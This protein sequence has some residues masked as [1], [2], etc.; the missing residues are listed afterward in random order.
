[1]AQIWLLMTYDLSQTCIA[2]DLD[3][4]LVD[5]AED[6]IGALNLVLSEI[7]VSA[8][9][10][11]KARNLVGRGARALIVRGLT[12][13]GVTASDSEVDALQRRFIDLYRDH[14][15]DH[16]KPFDGLMPCLDQLKAMRARLC[17]CT[18]KPYALSVLLLE[19][20]D[21]LDRFEAVFGADSVPNKKPDPAHLKACADAVGLPLD[22][23]LLIGDSETDHLTSRNANRPSILFS[24]GYSDPPVGDLKADY[25]LDH[26]DQLIPAICAVLKPQ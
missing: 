26:Y 21:L 25:V 19:R 18:N 11:E 10:I 15:A 3:G 6:L 4:T 2:F 20:L 16:S 7:K 14:I 12:A 24:F 8:I 17:V 13:A 5:T 22:Q 9:P 1:M 23:T